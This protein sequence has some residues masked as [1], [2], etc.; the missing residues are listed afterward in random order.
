M[1]NLDTIMKEKN[2][3]SETLAGYLFMSTRAVD[4][5][6]EGKSKPLVDIALKVAGYLSVPVDTLFEEE[7]KVVNEQAQ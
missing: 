4:N 3:P 7:S 6:R 2:I 1:T 5:W